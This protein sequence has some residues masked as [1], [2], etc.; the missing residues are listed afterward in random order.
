MN[1]WK[2]ARGVPGDFSQSDVKKIIIIKF[3]KKNKGSV[4]KIQEK[5][6]LIPCAMVAGEERGGGGRK[7][8]SVKAHLYT[9]ENHYKGTS[10]NKNQRSGIPSVRC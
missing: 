2:K 4:W 1:F 5:H 9:F 7:T 10:C 6:L 3:K 8:L